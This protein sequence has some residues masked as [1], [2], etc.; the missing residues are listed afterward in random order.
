VSQGAP[1]RDLRAR[2]VTRSPGHCGV[3]DD[4][5]HNVTQP[6]AT[7]DPAIATRIITLDRCDRRFTSRKEVL[8]HAGGRIELSA[9]PPR[10]LKSP[11][12]AS[13]LWRTSPLFRHIPTRVTIIRHAIYVGRHT[14][15]VNVILTT[16]GFACA[17]RVVVPRSSSPPK[18]ARRN[19]ADHSNQ[20]A[21]CSSA[22]CISFTQKSKIFS[23]NSWSPA[24]I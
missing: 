14:R 7:T 2:R 12:C 21:S 16:T 20:R 6:V 24:P 23:C 11:S 4:E 3:V 13:T 1:D 19:P 15:T 17:G 10:G 22:R 5:S 18:T 8:I 9:S